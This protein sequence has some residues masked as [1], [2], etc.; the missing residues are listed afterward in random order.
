MKATKWF[1]GLTILGITGY[2]T[3]KYWMPY[4]KSPVKDS[5]EK[6]AVTNTNTVTEEA[7]PVADPTK[8]ISKEKA[9]ELLGFYVKKQA[10]MSS[11]KLTDEGSKLANAVLASL[12]KAIEDGGWMIAPEEGTRKLTVVKIINL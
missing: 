10:D 2:A 8:A 1:V 6:P 5:K 12:R 11:S 9:I 4:F 7:K 3:R